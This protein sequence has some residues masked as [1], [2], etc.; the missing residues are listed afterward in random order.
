MS[1]GGGFSLVRA[2]ERSDKHEIVKRRQAKVFSWG[3]TAMGRLGQGKSRKSSVD[4][5][6]SQIPWCQF[7]PKVIPTLSEEDVIDIAAGM[8][9]ALAVNNKGE[10]YAWGSNS[11][12][13]CSVVDYNK[14]ELTVFEMNRHYDQLRGLDQETTPSI[15]DDIWVPRKL[16]YFGNTTT[17][18][19][20]ISVAAGDIHS[21]AL[22][23]DGRVYS[24]GGGGQNYCLGHGDIAMY[25]YGI[26]H[27]VDVSKRQFKAMSGNLEPPNWAMPRLINGLLH[28]KITRIS[29]GA[30][31]GAA[32]T[33]S[34]TFYVW[35]DHFQDL[36]EVIVIVI[37][38]TIWNTSYLYIKSNEKK[39][40]SIN[41]K[42]K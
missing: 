24:W 22:D 38:V 2:S 26:L 1:C 29:L 23:K 3:L 14:D 4:S 33:D 10:V 36:K 20:V 34:D 8:K 21:A 7:S 6:Q 12:G 37:S 40:F 5:N 15:W 42:L 35:G 28:S 16:P 17:N 32:L 41:R 19:Q 13:E 39:L 27:Q 9:H 18:I 25:E 11:A 31:H 30:K